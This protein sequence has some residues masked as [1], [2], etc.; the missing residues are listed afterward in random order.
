MPIDLVIPTFP[1]TQLVRELKQQIE[2]LW[3]AIGARI[4][5][6]QGFQ[7]TTTTSTDAKSISKLDTWSYFITPASLLEPQKISATLIKAPIE[8]RN[9]HL[10]SILYFKFHGQETD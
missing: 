4:K 2:D 1:L 7:S 5:D 9:K 10:S 8:F 6:Q 3:K